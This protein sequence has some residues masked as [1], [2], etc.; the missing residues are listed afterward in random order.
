MEN[1]SSGTYFD[2]LTQLLKEPGN[3]FSKIP[4]DA[5]FKEPFKFLFLSG[6]FFMI[7]SLISNMPE[8]PVIMG[9]IF[10]INA[11]GIAFITC[12]LAYMTMVMIMGKR[13][14]FAR[15]FGIYAFSSGVTLLASWIPFGFIIAEPWKWFLIGTGMT[16]SCGFRLSQA[17]LII[18][19]SVGALYLLFWSALPLVAQR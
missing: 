17:I 13:V 2:T 15:L 8:K 5:G 1:F 12:G 16:R 4:Q 11:I 10:L 9:M 14:T 7:A 18:A 3:F 6:L 19:V